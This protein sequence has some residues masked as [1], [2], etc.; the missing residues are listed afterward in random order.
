MISTSVACEIAEIR[1]LEEDAII[2]QGFRADQYV[3]RKWDSEIV[4]AYENDAYELRP[5]L[6]D[7]QSNPE[8][9]TERGNQESR[10]EDWNFM[11]KSEARI[12]VFGNDRLFPEMEVDLPPYDGETDILLALGPPLG[13]TLGFPLRDASGTISFNEFTNQQEHGA[14]AGELLNRAQQEIASAL[15]VSDPEQI[16]S[17]EKQAQF[18][19]CPTGETEGCTIREEYEGR[20]IRF[21]GAMK[22]TLEQDLSPGNWSSI[23]V[24]PVKLEVL[25]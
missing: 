17:E 2:K 4:P 18:V 3:E 10:G 11:V 8:V 24:V 20:T 5:L 15:G 19:N 25:D 14:V 22:L 12:L 16:E 1:T 13:T 23:K 21:Y 7:I 6:E 9:M